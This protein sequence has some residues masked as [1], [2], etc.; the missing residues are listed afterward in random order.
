L[1]GSIKSS[2]SKNISS[3]LDCLEEVKAR[4]YGNAIS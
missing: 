1:L 3:F 4:G 2:D